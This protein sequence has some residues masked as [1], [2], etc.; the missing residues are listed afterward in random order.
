MS[1]FARYPCHLTRQTCLKRATE[2]NKGQRVRRATLISY[3]H[4]RV[5]SHAKRVT[6]KHACPCHHHFT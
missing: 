3:G 2:Q 1:F 6:L 5:L 4:I